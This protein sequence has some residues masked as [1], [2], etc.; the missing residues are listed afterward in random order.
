MELKSFIKTFDNVVKVKALSSL[1]K[2]ANTAD[3]QNAAIGGDNNINKN[4][5][6]TKLFSLN[7]HSKSL[8]NIHWHNFLFFIFKNY[9]DHYKNELN[10]KDF[11]LT[12]IQSID[13]LKYDVD[14]KYVWHVDHFKD[15]PRT[16]SIIYLLNNDYKG[17]NLKFRDPNGE[18][19][20]SIETKANRLIMWPSNFLYPHSVSPVTEGTR[21]SIVS[22]SI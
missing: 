16:M 17:G 5:R 3:F 7:A 10:I 2:Y 6:S 15:I 4:V 14:D 1:I 20:F 19:E 22:W 12:T 13:I 8:T 21:Y 11:Q 9:L 18:N